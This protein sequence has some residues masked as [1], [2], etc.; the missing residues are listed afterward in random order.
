MK[1]HVP[2]T[3][4][5][6]LLGAYRH[7][8]NWGKD[9]VTVEILAHAVLAEVGDIGHAAMQR[10]QHQCVRVGLVLPGEGGGVEW[11]LRV[12]I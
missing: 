11:W 8:P 12:E 4:R 7:F 1:L 3:V 5:T 10:V 9:S 2:R 6:I